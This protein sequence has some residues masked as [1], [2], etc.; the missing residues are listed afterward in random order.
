[1]KN[2]FKIVDGY[3]QTYSGKTAIDD[4]WQEF[5]V[6]D[7]VYSP[8][9]LNDAIVALETKEAKANKINEIKQDC[10]ANDPVSLSVIF[11]DAT[12]KNITFNGGDSSAAAISGAIELATTLGETQVALWDSNNIVHTGISFDE[13]LSISVSIAKKYRDDMIK[14]QGLLNQIDAATTKEELELI[15]WN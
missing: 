10:T 14:R 11:K 12:T 2:Y 9:E 3:P 6:T 7:G 13:A 8:A 15:T 1:M 5:T 4:T